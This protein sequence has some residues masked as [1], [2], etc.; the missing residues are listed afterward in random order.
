MN[1]VMDIYSEAIEIQEVSL[2]ESVKRNFKT[3]FP[4]FDDYMSMVK[5]YH[6]DEE[7]PTDF[8]EA[9]IAE[10]KADYEEAMNQ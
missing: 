3:L 10:F 5:D 9:Q 4:T 2:I 8:S 7:L 6:E 1:T